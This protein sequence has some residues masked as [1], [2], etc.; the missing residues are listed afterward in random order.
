MPE[1]KK[2]FINYVKQNN[3]KW[4][5]QR[6]HIIDIFLSA[7]GHVTAEELYHLA[8]KKYP[9]IGSATVY[10]TLKLLSSC[11]LAT[12]ARFG[13]KF[14]RYESTQKSRHHDHLICTE[15][16]RILEF[17]SDQIEKL[18]KTVAQQHGFT[19]T[20]HKLV[21]YGICKSCGSTIQ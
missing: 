3:G 4:S 2:Q 9:H 20:H 7:D 21:L 15:C 19:I 1:L 11:G 14:A 5:K 10:R 6:D 18:Q 12:A 17:A 8:R 13:H 16:G